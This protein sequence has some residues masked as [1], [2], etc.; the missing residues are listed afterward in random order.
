MSSRVAKK[1]LRSLLE[2][3]DKALVRNAM[4]K[5]ERRKRRRKDEEVAVKRQRKGVKN[6]IGGCRALAVRHFFPLT[7]AGA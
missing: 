6:A 3:Q 2:A 4:P 7:R 5:A 1:Q